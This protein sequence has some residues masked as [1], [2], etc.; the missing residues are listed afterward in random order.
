MGDG[1]FES[2]RSMVGFAMR[3][4]DSSVLNEVGGIGKHKVEGVLFAGRVFGVL[5]ELVYLGEVIESKRLGA[6]SWFG[7]SFPVQFSKVEIANDYGWVGAGR[8]IT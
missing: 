3:W 1:E 8:E 7:V 2:D 4:G 5:N 6:D